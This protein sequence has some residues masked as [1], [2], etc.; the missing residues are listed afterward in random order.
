MYMYEV[1]QMWTSIF[2][3]VLIIMIIM[4]ICTAQVIII[5]IILIITKTCN[6][7]IHPVI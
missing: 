4:G 1:S 6:A 7:H 5:L 2:E 3:I